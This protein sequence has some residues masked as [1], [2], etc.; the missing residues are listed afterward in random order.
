[1]KSVIFSL[2]LKTQVRKI[3]IW[4]IKIIVKY[5]FEGLTRG[6]GLGNLKIRKKIFRSSIEEQFN[7]DNKITI[8]NRSFPRPL[9]KM[10]ISTNKPQCFCLMR[11]NEVY[12]W[13]GCGDPP[14][15]EG[16]QSSQEEEVADGN[17]PQH[18]H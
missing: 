7:I 2:I 17:N 13:T 12:W 9:M 16:S 4:K 6:L 1:M 3:V 14:H 10:S 8:F 15:F 11:F 18:Q 5:N